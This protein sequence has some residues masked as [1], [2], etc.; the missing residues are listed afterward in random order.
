MGA[1]SNQS[2]SPK[3]VNDLVAETSYQSINQIKSSQHHDQ[4]AIA[5]TVQQS[6][7]EIKK[8][9]EHTN[10][11]LHGNDFF[12]FGAWYLVALCVAA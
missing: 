6:T 11:L 12:T 5:E 2:R 3:L 1:V 10:V 8:L 9:F 7:K 4:I